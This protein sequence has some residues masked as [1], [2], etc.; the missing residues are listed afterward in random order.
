[1]TTA[2]NLREMDAAIFTDKPLGLR[3][4]SPLSLDERFEY[5]AD[6]NV[7][8]I[9]FEGLKLQT[10][11]HVEMLAAFLDRRLR[12]LGRRVN[13]IVNYDNFDLRSAAT[14]R[15]FAM[16][17]EMEQRH[18]L[19]S[20]RYSTQAF[21][22]LKLGQAFASAKFSQTIYRS[23]EEATHALSEPARQ[24]SHEARFGDGGG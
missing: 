12:D 15:F 14:A 22:R 1:V 16:A 23:F 21:Y 8:F 13:L 24:R 6:D 11:D 17:R 4:R 3:Q 2:S 7:V 19:S 18:F 5:R 20:T 9:N 10:V